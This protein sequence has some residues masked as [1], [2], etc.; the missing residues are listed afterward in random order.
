MIYNRSW[1]SLSIETLLKLIS[2][3]CRFWW[4]SE[5]HRGIPGAPGRVVNLLEADDPEAKVWGVA[6][7]IND[8]LWEKEIKAHLDHRHQCCRLLIMP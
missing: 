2:L 4:W 7:S 5:D 8:E 6:Y 3:L 1:S